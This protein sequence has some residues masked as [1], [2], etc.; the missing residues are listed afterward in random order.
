MSA[1]IGQNV[2]LLIGDA[3]DPGIPERKAQVRC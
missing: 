1:M 2:S 3:S